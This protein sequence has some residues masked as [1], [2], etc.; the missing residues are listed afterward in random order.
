[1]A[2]IGIIGASGFV[3][4]HLASMA[5]DDGHEAVLFSRSPRPGY[6]LLADDLSSSFESLDAVVNLAGEPVMGL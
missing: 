5:R 6:E 1:M 4:R 2:K 3:G